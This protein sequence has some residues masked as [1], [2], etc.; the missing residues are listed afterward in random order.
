AAAITRSVPDLVRR[1]SV[2]VTTPGGAEVY[3]GPIELLVVSTTPWYGRGLRVNPG[4]RPDAG[5]LTMR[6]Y[7]GPLPSFA[8]EVARWLAHRQ[9]SVPA[10]AGTEFLVR[11]SDGQPLI[12]QADGDAIGRRTEW[13]FRLRPAAVRLIGRW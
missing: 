2:F 11:A 7:P 13:S 8:V 5:T 1:Q 6:V 9:P 10:T 4:A 12:L 3:R